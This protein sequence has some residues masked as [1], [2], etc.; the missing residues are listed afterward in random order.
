MQQQKYLWCQ[1]VW[2]KNYEP[3]RVMGEDK[4]WVDS[5]EKKTKVSGR[6]HQKS[7]TQRQ[8]E[9]SQISEFLHSQYSM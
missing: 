7:E 3:A 8:T 4:R 5:H 2:D 1:R 9:F 6:C